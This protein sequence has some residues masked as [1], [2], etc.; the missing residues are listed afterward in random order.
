MQKNNH[1]SLRWMLR[2]YLFLCVI[3]LIVFVPLFPLQGS[4]QIESV[5]ISH[6]YEPSAMEGIELQQL[7]KEMTLGYQFRDLN[8][9]IQTLLI[10]AVGFGAGMTLFS[11]LVS[12]RQSLLFASLPVTRLWAWTLRVLTFL[13]LCAVPAVLCLSVYPLLI[14]ANGFFAVFNLRFYLIRAFS[15]VILLLYG[16]SLGA[17]C[18]AVCG[19]F[20]SAGLMALVL[21]VSGEGF[22]LCWRTLVSGYLS[23]IPGYGLK[24]R[25]I[26][27]VGSLYKSFYEPYLPFPWAGLLAM[28]LFLGLSLAAFLVNRPENAGKTLNLKA[29][30]KPGLLW[31]CMLGAAVGGV[32]CT[33]MAPE[34]ADI[35]IPAGI[36]LGSGLTWLMTR[37]L[38]EQ[39]VRISPRYR[40]IPVLCAVLTL[41]GAGILRLDLFG[42][43]SYL[44]EAASL[45]SVTVQTSVN[46]ESYLPLHITKEKSPDGYTDV[47]SAES[48]VRFQKP[49]T[50]NACLNWVRV[51][52]E[53]AAE[54]R[55]EIPFQRWPDRSIT[56]IFETDGG[57]VVRNY[58]TPWGDMQK[59]ALPFFRILAESDEF[60]EQQTMEPC[61]AYE[62]TFTFL[63]DEY[64]SIT[65]RKEAEA[66]REA[67]LKDLRERTLEDMQR[68]VLFSFYSIHT[69]DMDFPAAASQTHGAVLSTDQHTLRML[70]QM[71]NE[72]INRY[73]DDA[74][75]GYAENPNRQFFLCRLDKEGRFL[76]AERI[77][78]P[79]EIR[80]WT[81]RRVTHCT[82][83]VAAYPVDTAWQLQV[84]SEDPRLVLE[85]GQL[86]PA[87]DQ[88][89]GESAAE[90]AVFQVIDAE[91]EGS[92]PHE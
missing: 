5:R 63:C 69:S 32:L 84:W 74:L 16:F 92:D 70:R 22:L 29:L 44:P 40:M 49:E 15:A 8:L 77:S 57:R 10:L 88:E 9:E 85:D 54:V 56:V 38:L 11:P 79:D 72:E 34:S 76:S 67:H 14:A 55:K 78:S 73:L 82:E 12:R 60:R 2:H 87:I 1:S 19:T 58:P 36:L 62:L 91:W 28:L 66:F 64:R 86:I 33:Y 23:T 52:Q 37:M 83:A 65:F 45:R 90:L 25:L 75:G 21:A 59:K 41:L 35:G 48:S 13:I 18:P 17:L 46:W 30:E 68:P 89:T 39:T 47:Y 20:W 7:T 61:S 26:S 53:N 43:N 24:E 3:V 6:L 71:E 27:P 42:Y 31:L 50:M 4:S 51:L 80:D 81:I